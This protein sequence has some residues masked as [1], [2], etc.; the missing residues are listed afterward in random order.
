MNFEVWGLTGTLAT[1]RDDQ[2]DFAEARL[3]HWLEAVD[4]A[5]NRFK[6]DSELSRLNARVGEAIEIGATLA[7]AL[8]AAWRAYDATSGLCDPTVL[9]SLVALGYDADYE[10]LVEREDAP[11]PEPVRPP[12]L[13]AIRY[14]R[15]ARTVTLAPGCQLDFGATAKALVVDLVAADVA[16]TGGVVVEVGGDVALRGHGP[17][18]PWS[19]GIADSLRLRGDEPRVS[20][21][22]GAIAT[23][24]TTAR[25]WRAGGRT[26]HHVIDPRTGEPAEG[27]WATVSVSARSCVIANALSTAALLWG[28]GA[29]SRVARSGSAG[30][31]VRHDG[32]VEYAG[33]WPPDEERA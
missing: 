1:E 24:S 9:A 19:I 17:D 7:L 29:A 23:S 8:D 27:P 32:T 12:G 15:R 28:D 25:T 5:C 10:T 31:F 14:D 6:P 2:R 11:L 33:G 18:G 21:E 13:G 22:D 26:L 4:A 3:W 30:R 16:P 20:V